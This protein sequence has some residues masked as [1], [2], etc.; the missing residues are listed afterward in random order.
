MANIARVLVLCADGVESSALGIPPG[1]KVHQLNSVRTI[2]DLPTSG[3]YDLGIVIN[4]L[5]HMTQKNGEQVLARLRDV[6]CR[7]ILVDSGSA[8]WAKSSLLAL[9]FLPSPPPDGWQR[10]EQL[11]QYDIDRYNPPRE[12]NTPAGWAH[13]EN[14]GKFRW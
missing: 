3:R 7:K 9:G 4:Q 5:E 2:D 11:Y 14:Y 13:P 6:L 12:W 1:S 8:N 10:G